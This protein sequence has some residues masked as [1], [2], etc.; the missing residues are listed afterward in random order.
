[1][2]RKS[3]IVLSFLVLFLLIAV[4]VFMGPYYLKV[5]YYPPDAGKGYHAGYY[6]YVSPGAKKTGESGRAV[7]FLIQPNNTGTISDDAKVHQ[8]EAWW[9]G[10]ERHKIAN[11]LNV[12]L[13]VPAFIRPAQDWHIYTHALDRD[14]LT[15]K[16]EDLKRIDLQLIAMIDEARVLLK[17]EG[18]ESHEK[19]LIQG[20]SASGMFANRFTVLH[21]ERVLATVFGSPGGWPIAPVKNYKH[22]FLPYPAG[23]GDL[24]ALTGKP[25]DSAT[26]VSIPQ[27][28]ILGS[29]DDN[30]SLDFTDG[31]DKEAAGLVDGFFGKD[32]LS[33]WPHAESIY[34]QAGASVKFILV[35]GVGHDRKKLQ[36][37]GVDFFAEVLSQ[38]PH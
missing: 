32:P 31:W 38:N 18:M 26:Y 11:A 22:F 1:M 21:P 25:F 29:A 28:S 9:T 27:L 16:R 6:L 17:S 3:L 13:L 2:L 12:V 37:Y 10:F 23:I 8:K 4:V 35:E 34:K 33:R 20:F 30:D 14:V 19:F 24:E 36:S 7:T 5:R 15:T